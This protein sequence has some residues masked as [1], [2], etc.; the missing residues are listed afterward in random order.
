MGIATSAANTAQNPSPIYIWGNDSNCQPMPAVTA[1]YTPNTNI[2]LNT[3]FFVSATQPGSM[4]RWQQAA[5]TS[6]T[7]Y[8]YT[9]FV[10]PYPLDT[11]GL[12]LG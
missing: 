2:A 12:P 11:N 1:N 9:S 6:S 7:T 10:Y 3:Q 4:K 8:S 5:D